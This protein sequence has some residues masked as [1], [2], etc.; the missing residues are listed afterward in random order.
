[1]TKHLNKVLDDENLCPY[2]KH[3]EDK[4]L[5]KNNKLKYMTTLLSGLNDKIDY[6][7]LIK[8]HQKL[9]ITEDDY[10][11]YKSLLSAQMKA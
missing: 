9:K 10:E 5:L 4:E 3:I 7:S 6:D 2:H 11:K 8:V 1:V